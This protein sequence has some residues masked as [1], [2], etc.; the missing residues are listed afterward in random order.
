MTAAHLAPMKLKTYAMKTR[1]ITLLPILMLLPY[2]ESLSMLLRG[3][4]AQPSGLRMNPVSSSVPAKLAPAL[5]SG[6]RMNPVSSSGPANSRHLPIDSSVFTSDPALAIVAGSGG[7]DYY[8][9]A[10]TG[11]NTGDTRRGTGACTAFRRTLQCDPSGPRAPL[12]DKG[13]AQIVNADESGFCEC[14][15]YAQFAAVNCAHRPF[16]CEVMCLKFAVVTGRQAVFRTQP[17]SPAAARQL[18]DQVMWANQTDLEAMRSMTKDIES[19]M[20]KALELNNARAD[21]AR[22]SMATYLDMMKKARKVDAK[23]AA[24][25]W[26]NYRMALKNDPWVQIYRNGDDLI[27]TGKA[28]QEKVVEALPFDPVAPQHPAM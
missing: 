16:T 17:L 3:A 11:E 22:Q 9:E 19:F 24:E 27:K 10:W 15:D 18:L 5:P 2:G 4:L 25:E 28:I 12:Q 21:N 14:G 23:A 7:G 6:L 13:C 26:H 20:A 8:T 1:C